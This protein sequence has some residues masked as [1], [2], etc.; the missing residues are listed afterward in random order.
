MICKVCHIEFKETHF[1]QKCCSD[2]CKHQAKRNTQDK[3]KKSEKGKSSYQRWCKNPVKKEIDKK[4]MQT[5]KAKKKAVIRSTRALK[6]NQSLQEKK[7]I[8]DRLFAKTEYGRE[9]NN[10]AKRKYA[11]TEKGRTI[12]LQCKYR[13]RNYSAGKFDMEAWKEKLESLHYKCQMCGTDERIT[14]D[15]IIPLSKG[16]TNH[17]DNLQPLCHSCNSSKNN[18]LMV[19]V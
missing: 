4:Y 7:R 17:I 11:H 1:N 18:K 3:Y 8:R 13:R 12:M 2:E 10:N 9:L 6:N 14:I 5:E 19:A 15:H 16:G